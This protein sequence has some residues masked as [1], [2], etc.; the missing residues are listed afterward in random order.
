MRHPFLLLCS[1][2]ALSAASCA[3]KPAAVVKPIAPQDYYY[4][5]NPERVWNALL[6]VYTDLNVPIENMDRASWFMRSRDMMLPPADARA[7][8]QCGAGKGV[9]VTISVTTLLRASGDS[10]AMRLNVHVEATRNTGNERV[11]IACAS[12]GVLEQRV[13][14]SVR[15][16]L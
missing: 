5:V 1:C 7:W 9:N 11:A 4:K 14:E 6:L 12:K 8:M 10:T 15:Q 2:L 16:R 13:V 3:S